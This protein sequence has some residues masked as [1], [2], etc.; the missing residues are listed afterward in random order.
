MN[1]P[2]SGLPKKSVHELVKEEEKKN[3]KNSK[4]KR[5]FLGLIVFY[6]LPLASI[7]IFIGLFVFVIFP[8]VRGIMDYNEEIKEKEEEIEDLEDEIA[9]LEELEDS[10]LQTQDDLETINEIVP[11][12]KVEVTKFVKEVLDIA[13]QQGLEQS[14][15]ST[16]ET[17]EEFDDDEDQR[18]A[19]IRVLTTSEYVASLDDIQDFLNALYKKDDFI[20]VHS[21]ELQGHAAREYYESLQEEQGL[22]V[23]RRSGLSINDW[24]MEVTFEKY[25]FGED[26][27]EY[28]LESNYDIDDEPDESV[29]KFIRDRYGK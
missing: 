15:Q 9:T 27:D 17:I 3:E 18:A 29:L 12:G 16:G 1:E 7:A 2:S 10:S 14:S 5:S 23:E 8:L 6:S 4:K 25:S 13:E 26:F 24:T 11:T 28:I 20:I 21:L 19:I 22:E